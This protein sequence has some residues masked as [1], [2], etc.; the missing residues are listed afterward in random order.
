MKF[1]RCLILCLAVTLSSSASDDVYLFSYFVG[2]GEDGLHLAW[3]EAGYH[4]EAVNEGRSF[5]TP[6]IGH[7]E[8]LMR[9]PC[10]VQGPDG[11]YHLVW[12]SGW[13]EAGIGYASTRDFITWSPQR[14]IPVMGHEPGVRNCWAPEIVYDETRGEFVI[15]W[16]STVTGAFSETAGASEEAYNHRMYATTTR[17]FVTFTPTRLFYDPGFSV[18]D[19][20]FLRRADGH[21]D[22]IVKDET[23]NPVKKHLRRASAESVQGPFGELGSP[24]TPDGVWVEG[25]T[26]IAIGSE[27]LV[28]FDAYQ[29]R[30][31]GAMRSRDGGK[32]WTDVSAEMHFPF[33]GTE[34]R[35]RHGTVFKVSRSLM[36]KLANPALQR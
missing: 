1:I 8:K 23:V 9:D 25:P 3:S 31:Y 27:V 6:E 16:A 36:G 29:V 11:V 12:T 34:R 21:L 24:F 4:W 18:I 28:Y 17:D 22:W 30:R 10:V 14:E 26:A 7:K 32:T 15:F 35:M 13:K 19:A 2:N 20:T 33:E 5:L